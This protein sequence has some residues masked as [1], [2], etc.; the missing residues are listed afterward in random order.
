MRREIHESGDTRRRTADDGNEDDRRWGEGTQPSFAIGTRGIELSVLESFE[1]DTALDL[2]VIAH[3]VVIVSSDGR[4]MD[5]NERV[6]HLTGFL[7]TELVGQRISTLADDLW[8]RSRHVRSAVIGVRC[9]DGHEQPV[10]VVISP[11]RAGSTVLFMTPHVPRESARDSEVVQIVHDLK[12]PLATIALELCL[13]EDKLH[14]PEL[15]GR[16]ARVTQ[17]VAFLDRMVQD[18]LDASALDAERFE[19]QRRPTELR[20]LIEYAV[21]RSVSSRDRPR[22]FVDARCSVTLLIDDLRIERVICNLLQNALKYSPSSAG[23]VIRL[24]RTETIA[25]VSVTDDG[26]GISDEDQE[27]IFDEFGRGNAALAH[28]GHGLGLYISKR[29]V[30]AHG[31]RISVHS[32]RGAG[33]CFYFELPLTE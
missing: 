21:D 30:E 16:V 2:S 5:V 6:E 19:L 7:R 31:G 20:T 25:R 32:I 4:I 12:N 8:P 15:K 24:D 9:H 18:L 22:V 33:A 3:A 29:I 23:V 1:Q 26:P 27:L 17:N 10:D 13:L 14:Q 11:Y 28:Q